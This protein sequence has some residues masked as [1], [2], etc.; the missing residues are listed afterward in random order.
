MR[1]AF[2][3]AAVTLAVLAPSPAHAA[4]VYRWIDEA[5]NPHF[6][7]NPYSV[8][9]GYRAR[10]LKPPPPRPP[11]AASTAPRKSPSAA[12]AVREGAR[13]SA[14]DALLLEE[15]LKTRPGDLTDR[16][17]LLG[18]Y[19]SQSLTAVGPVAT[20]EARRRHI[21]WLIENHPEAELAGLSEAT[22]DR[23]G[24]ALADPPGY[25]Q[26]RKLWLEQV[27]RRP[28]EAAVLRHAAKFFTLPDKELAE[29]LLEQGQ[30]AEPQNAAWGDQLAFLHAL[31]VMAVDGLNK[32]GL[33]TSVDVA[34]ETGSFARKSRR[35][36]EG[37]T[38]ASE[39]LVAG[40]ILAM[41]GSMLRGMRL[42]Q[43]DHSLLA[44]QLLKK[45][46]TLGAPR[47]QVADELTQLYEL[48]RQLNAAGK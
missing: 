48:R 5:G 34:Q 3:A 16:A 25:E 27:R 13:L 24:H 10:P 33:P 21:L 46:E 26:A 47:Q 22:I 17:R 19:F 37:S 12:Q 28:A 29:R 7:D 8:P 4:P 38:R 2:L 35:A 14:Y 30:K 36:L 41:Y 39:L 32:N 40:R 42:T 45:A 18:Y 44:E 20:V 23:A 43:Q 9:E 1:T 11:A 6:T 31:G 15:R